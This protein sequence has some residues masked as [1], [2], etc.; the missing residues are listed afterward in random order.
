MG[1]PKKRDKKPLARETSGEGAAPR[2][3]RETSPTSEER[4]EPQ[5]GNESEDD[6]RL[7]D[8]KRDARNPRGL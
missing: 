3:R 4:A 2:K 6:A 7:I 5:R 8:R 1:E